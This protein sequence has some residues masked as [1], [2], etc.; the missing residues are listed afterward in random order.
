MENKVLT[1]AALA[2]VIIVLIIISRRQKDAEQEKKRREKLL[3][4][5][6]ELI[7][8]LLLYLKAGLVCRSA[9]FRIAADYKKE[10]DSGKPVRPA[11]EE[12]TAACRDM[13]KGLGEVESYRKFGRRCVLPSYRMLSVLLEQNIKKGGPALTEQLEREMITAYEERRRLARIEGERASIKLL[14]PMGMMLIVV[15]A[16]V[17]VPAMIS[18]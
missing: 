13:E 4:D 18:F 10:S 3:A 15:M 14:L 5:Y 11:F 7:S 8:R 16:I 9:F 2:G 1:L 17:I 12:L 6:P